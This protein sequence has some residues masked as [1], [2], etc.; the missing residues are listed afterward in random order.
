MPRFLC[1]KGPASAYST[2]TA[3][4]AAVFHYNWPTEFEY[5]IREEEETWVEY[6]SLCHEFCLSCRAA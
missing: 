3:R 2:T 6:N 1:F 5:S 4:A